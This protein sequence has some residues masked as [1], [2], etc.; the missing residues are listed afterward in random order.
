MPYKEKVTATQSWAD[1]PT[2]ASAGIPVEYLMLRGIFMPPGVA[3]D[4][5]NFYTDLFAKIACAARVEGV[6]GEGAFK[7]SALSGQP[8]VDWLGQNEQ[9]HRVL[10]KEPAS[11]PSDGAMPAGEPHDGR[12]RS[13][14][15]SPI[16]NGRS[17][18]AARRSVAPDLFLLAASARWW[19][20][21][22]CAWAS[23]G[24]RR[25]PALGYFPFYMGCC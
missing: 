11:W 12:R 16:W 1:L 3:P 9:M 25:R 17:A 23:A 14:A 18:A 19:W 22:A 7:D 21:T 4:Q 8:F 5:V 6:H 20:A 15:F 2:C 24:R 13:D 10:M